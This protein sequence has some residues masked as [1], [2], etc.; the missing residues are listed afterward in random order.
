MGN[1]QWLSFIFNYLRDNKNEE[2]ILKT[3][4]DGMNYEDVFPED[5]KCYELLAKFIV[6]L[7]LEGKEDILKELEDVV[8]TYNKKIFEERGKFITI[9]KGAVSIYQDTINILH[10]EFQD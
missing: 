5:N 8:H 10:N 3:S 1:P 6:Y 9:Y 7:H 2:E 4:L